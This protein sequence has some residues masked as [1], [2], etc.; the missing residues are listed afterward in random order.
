MNSTLGRKRR[1]VSG[2]MQVAMIVGIVIIFSGVL[3]TFAGDIFDVQ[4]VA[5]SISLQKVFV[6]KV[7]DETFISVNTKN[8][9]NSDITEIDV[10]VMVDTN[11]A[12]GVQPFTTSISPSPLR[13]GMTGSAYERLT[14]S[15]GTNVDLSTGSEIAVI[16]NATTTDGS[17]LTEP[18]TVR[19]R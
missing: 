17:M 1:G 16:L 8:T 18:V 3:F 12:N 4:T 14:N 6:Q 11:P 13:P 15:D 7:G 19:V 10:R 5:D 9:G 2:L